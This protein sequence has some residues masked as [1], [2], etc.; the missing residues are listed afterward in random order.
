MQDAASRT[1]LHDAWSPSDIWLL[2]GRAVFWLTVFAV[3]VVLNFR[4][5]LRRLAA[6]YS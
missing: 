3:G 1:S 4:W 2:T 6:R 5:V